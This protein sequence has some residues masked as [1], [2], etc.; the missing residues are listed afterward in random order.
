MKKQVIEGEAET[1]KKKSH[2]KVS[3]ASYCIV[4]HLV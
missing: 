2:K 1:H 3:C 4:D